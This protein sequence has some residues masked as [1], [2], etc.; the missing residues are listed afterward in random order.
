[1]SKWQ[2]IEDWELSLSDDGEELHINYGANKDGNKY[3]SVKI[4]DI[5]T[6]ID[7]SRLV[8]E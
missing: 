6:L 3:L 1:M 8:K 7:Q 5:L 4:D 2:E